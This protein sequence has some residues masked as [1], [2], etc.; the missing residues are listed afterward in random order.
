M[1]ADVLP[2]I[3]AAARR[4]YRGEFILKTVAITYQ[5]APEAP[6]DSLDLRRNGLT[7]LAA[8]RGCGRGRH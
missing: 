7:T 5:A 4:R 6:L 1:R 2:E 3:R 8:W